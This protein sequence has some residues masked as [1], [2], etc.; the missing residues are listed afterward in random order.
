MAIPLRPLQME[1]C[2]VKNLM[3]KGGGKSKGASFEREICGSL[4]RWVSAGTRD[5]IFWRSAMSGGRSTV[6]LKKGQVLAAQAG[7]I[8]SVHSEGYCFTNR[9]FV[10]VKFYK[11]L[12]FAASFNEKG[13][14]SEFWKVAKQEA[15]KYKRVPLLIARQ[16]R[17]PTLLC[18]NALGL[19]FLNCR[20]HV[21]VELPQQDMSICLFNKFLDTECSKSRL[22]FYDYSIAMRDFYHHRRGAED[23][24]IQFEF[25]FEEWVL[26]WEMHLGQ[27]WQKLRGRRRGQHVMARKG[28]TGPYAPWNVK[29]IT[30]E[31]NA[32]ERKEN[33]TAARGTQVWTNKLTE[34]QVIDIFNDP[35]HPKVLAAE[36]P[37]SVDMI[38][39]IKKKKSW[40]YLLEDLKNV[41]SGGRSTLNRQRKRLL[42]I[43]HI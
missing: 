3:R 30:Q 41:A 17:L 32:S 21:Q 24:G 38:W 34:S 20:E 18:T 2:Q 12:D 27:G 8:S 15:Q 35:R 10:E 43:R 7:D 28:D 11:N 40:Q 37:V 26:W 13:K 39:R 9:F 19:H 23:R 25:E 33:G 4:S 14:L 5:D 22:H 29:C 16:N 1:S 42:Q 31:A 36:Y 6:A